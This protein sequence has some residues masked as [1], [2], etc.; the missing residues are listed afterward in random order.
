LGLATWYGDAYHRARQTRSGERLNAKALTCAVPDELWPAVARRTLLVQRADGQREV[1]VRVNDSGYLSEAG[2]FVWEV[3]TVGE[4]D[5]ER[6][7]PSLDGLAIVV[8]LTPAAHKLLNPDG[9]TA[10]VCVWV[11][12]GSPSS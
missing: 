12:P 11:L 5:V 4:L 2:R 8:D 9:E 6:W 3:R 1:L 7:W 10:Q